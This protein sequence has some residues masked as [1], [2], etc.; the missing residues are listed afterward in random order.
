MHRQASFIPTFFPE[1]ADVD[2]FYFPAFEGEDLGQ[3]V[4]GAGTQFS[5]TE[6]SEATR[7]FIDFLKTPIAHEVWMA[8]SGFLTPYEGVNLELFADPTLRQMN[9]I[10]LNASTFRFDASDIMPSE[11]GAGAFWTGMVDYTT[12]EDADSVAQSIQDRWDAIQ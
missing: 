8:Q 5:I 11:I 6:D 3:P 12:G 4:L 10:L 9:E 7:G 2:F 1:D